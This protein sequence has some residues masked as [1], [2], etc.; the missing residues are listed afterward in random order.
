MFGCYWIICK[1]ISVPS[2][3]L[4]LKVFWAS[5]DSCWRN[6]LITAYLPIRILVTLWNPLTLWIEVHCGP[7]WE[8]QRISFFF[9][10]LSLTLW[11]LLTLLRLLNMWV[12]FNIMLMVN[13]S[14]CFHSKNKM[15]FILVHALLYAGDVVH[16]EADM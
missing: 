9:F 7:F 14:T 6:A 1:R 13:L 12:T 15:F 11:P 5:C 4:D 2:L 10:L 8:S 16:S 3:S